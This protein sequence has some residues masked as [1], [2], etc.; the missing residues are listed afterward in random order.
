[1]KSYSWCFAILLCGSLQAH[2]DLISPRVGDARH[3][4]RENPNTFDQTDNYC[5]GK[6]PQAP[7]VVAGSAF[8]GGGEGTCASDINDRG[9]IELSCVRNDEITIERKLPEG[10][11]VADE[12]VCGHYGGEM[13]GQKYN[14]TPLNPVPADQFCTGRPVG[15]ACTAELTYKGQKEKH[16]GIC[17]KVTETEEY[18][19]WGHRTMTRDVIRCEPPSIPERTYTPVSWTEKLIPR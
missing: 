14:C 18:Y 9:V 16:A 13:D 5:K 19:H 15:G 1:M 8:A 7:C 4:L 17:R 3:R 12:D 11:F 10:G 6:K 2:A